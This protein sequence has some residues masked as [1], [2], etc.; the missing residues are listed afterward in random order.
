MNPIDKL[1]SKVFFEGLN[2][3]PNELETVNKGIRDAQI[4]R[5]A[6]DAELD[7]VNL[8]EYMASVCIDPKLRSVLLDV[9]D[10]EKVHIGEFQKMLKL[11]DKEYEDLV[12]KGEEETKDVN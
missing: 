3:L 5:M 6:I 10:E 2:R 9:A 7:A 11:I 4:L 8:Y 1:L 12:N